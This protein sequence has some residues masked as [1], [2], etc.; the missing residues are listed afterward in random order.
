MNFQQNL[1][2][3]PIVLIVDD[4][5]ENLSLM[6]DLLQN[7]YRVKAANNGEKA[8]RIAQ[9]SPNP[10]L[11]LL[12]IMMPGMNGYQVCKHLKENRDTKEIPII[13][14]TAKTSIE[15]EQHGLELGAIDYIF[16]PVSPPI[17]RAR[18]KT[19]LQLKLA[20]DFLHNQNDFLEKEVHKRT[21]ELQSNQEV[22]ILALAALAETRD[23]DTGNHLRRTQ[24]YIKTLALYLRN[25]PK[26]HKFLTDSNIDMLFKSAPLHDIGK[27]GIPDSILL[28]PG[29]LTT[30][31]F[32]VMKKHPKLGWDAIENA[33][34]TLGIKLDFLKIAKEIVL[35]HHEKWD[36][37]GYPE[38]LVGEKIPISAR[39]MAIA[40]VYDA[41]IS[42]RVYKDGFAQNIAVE[43]IQEGRGK[44]FDPDMVDAFLDLKQEFLNISKKYE[45]RLE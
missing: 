10:D 8:I 17:I 1:D 27:V 16:K 26:F 38:G 42:R 2:N 21:L 45:D 24:L 13:F 30:E 28:K 43:I 20:S 32:E 9:S 22:T 44:H 29:K 41:L 25:H 34:K 39:F 7:D 3:K 23:N 35:Y 11:I 4:T 15:D 31:E 6:V 12:D 36:G 40:D 5:L 19:H 33:E 18:I 14:L 37:T